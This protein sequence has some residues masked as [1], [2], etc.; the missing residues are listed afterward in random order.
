MVEFRFEK[1]DAWKLAIEF[2]DRLY[3]ITKA[4]P[5]D[6]RFGLTSQ[7]RRA[8]SSV[9]A[10]I[11]EGA[12]RISDR[13]NLRFIEIAYGSLMEVISHLEVAHRQ[14]YLQSSDRENV[15]AAADQL[16]GLRNHLKDRVE[17]KL[18]RP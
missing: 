14:G 4:F 3:T 18:P 12:G 2:C 6:E 9:P 13:D 10:N 5:S 7:L 15:R 11:A 1:L 17:S 8:G 16:A